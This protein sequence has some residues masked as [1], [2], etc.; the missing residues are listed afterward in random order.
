M[1]H[2]MDNPGSCG[3]FDTYQRPEGF[4]VGMFPFPQPL[5]ALS[6]NKEICE[7]VHLY[8]EHRTSVSTSFTFE[9]TFTNIIS[10]EKIFSNKMHS[11][12]I[13]CVFDKDSTCTQYEHF[14]D[15]YAPHKHTH[16]HLNLIF[17][18]LNTD[19]FIFN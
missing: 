1:M 6:I 5:K 3:N 17:K 2:I 4:P 9:I 14:I 19:I 12:K 7:N 11:E 15:K 16:A 8:P 13:A 18:F 10:K